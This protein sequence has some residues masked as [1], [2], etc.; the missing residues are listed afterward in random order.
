MLLL[1]RS[2]RRLLGVSALLGLL[3]LAGAIYLPVVAQAPGLVIQQASLQLWP[4]YD[5]P[6]L[7]VIFSGRFTDTV[8]F[9]QQVAFPLPA[10][11]RDIQATMQDASGTLLVQPWQ[12][13]NG[14]LTYTLPGPAFHVEYYLDRPPS[15]NERE[16]NYTFEAAY[17]ILGLEVLLQ[18]P[19]RAIGFSATPQP[20]RSFPGPDG[21]IYHQLT[22]L[23]LAAGDRLP[24]TIRYTKTDQGP[25]VMDTKLTGSPSAPQPTAGSPAPRETRWLAL[26]LIGLGGAALTGAVVYWLLQRRRPSPI[27]EPGSRSKPVAPASGRV[28]RD[29]KSAFCTQC[30]R[31]LGP[32]D[33][34]CGS[35]G[36]PRRQ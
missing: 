33:R 11:A 27:P 5:D 9:P 8:A 31:Q 20:E 28:G 18:E 13:V 26:A 10:G 21:F 32:D 17:P 15:G 2:S 35:C 19:A 23:N 4:E 34:F 30:G 16:L 24:I 3:A 14:K 22:R 29:S 25:S 7:L 12:N 6:G 36:T 1:A